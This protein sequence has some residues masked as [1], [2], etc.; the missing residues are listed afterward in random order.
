MLYDFSEVELRDLPTVISAPRFAPY[1]RAMSNSRADA[2]ALYQWNFQISAA[3]FVPLQ[4]CEIAMR[5]GV[6]EALERV[7]GI[8]WPRSNGFIRS[9]PTPRDKRNYNAQ[10]DLFNVAR[11]HSTTGKVIAEVRLAFWQQIFTAGQDHRL[12]I[13]HLRTVF[14]GISHSIPVTAARANAYSSLYALRSLRNRIAHHEPIFR[15]DIAVEY[16][17]LR[18]MVSWRSLTAASWL[19][20]IEGV[21][22]LIKTKP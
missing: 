14:P 10:I 2:L 21:T 17:R 13:P 5:N 18:A 20:N 8:N 11:T 22:G 1:L 7:H 3:L 9:L 4:M 6:A 15:R 16:S 12:W 19:D